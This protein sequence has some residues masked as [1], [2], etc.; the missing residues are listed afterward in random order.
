MLTTEVTVE[1][2]ECCIFFHAQITKEETDGV[3]IQLHTLKGLLEFHPKINIFGSLTLKSNSLKSQIFNI[4]KFKI[5]LK[6]FPFFLNR[7]HSHSTS[8]S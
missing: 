5:F 3:P 7:R 6:K 8:Y 4:L 1:D 2:K